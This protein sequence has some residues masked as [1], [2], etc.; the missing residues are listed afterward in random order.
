M[1]MAATPCLA[2]P[3]LTTIYTPPAIGD[4]MESQGRLEFTGSGKTDFTGPLQSTGDSAMLNIS[5][6]T[7]RFGSTARNEIGGRGMRSKGKLNFD[8]AGRTDFTG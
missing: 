6:G 7:V 2:V 8:G 3:L 1:S 4:G 5:Q